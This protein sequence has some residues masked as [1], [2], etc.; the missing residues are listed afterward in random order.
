MKK[1]NISN[2]IIKINY[3]PKIHKN[4]KTII[5]VFEPQ[6]DILNAF[7]EFLGAK[8]LHICKIVDTIQT[9]EYAIY[10]QDVFAI[11][12]KEY[13]KLNNTP[14]E[15]KST[16]E[17][18]IN[19]RIASLKTSIISMFENL[20]FGTDKLKG[21]DL[22]EIVFIIDNLVVRFFPEF[23]LNHQDSETETIDIYHERYNEFYKSSF[24][25]N[26]EI[27]NWVIDIQLGINII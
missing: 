22:N 12:I 26:F 9:S 14:V 18:I 24:W 15:H 3:K 10:N 1:E 19:N 11:A 27:T 16:D 23:T 8:N 13:Y 21:K 20:L 4:M 5:P 6:D 25:K 17:I 2:Y 7:Q